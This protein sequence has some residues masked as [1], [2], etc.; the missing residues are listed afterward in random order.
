MIEIPKILFTLMIVFSL[1][2]CLFSAVATWIIIVVK[3]DDKRVDD[4]R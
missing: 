1:L 3:Q 4:N 2:G